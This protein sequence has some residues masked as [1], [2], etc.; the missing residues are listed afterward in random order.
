MNSLF[1]K[2][3]SLHLQ[4]QF[5]INQ[6]HAVFVNFSRKT[7][8]DAVCEQSDTTIIIRLSEYNY[9]TITLTS[10]HSFISIHSFVLISES[11]TTTTWYN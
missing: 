7:Q 6:A 1:R 9:L 4:Q 8:E 5:T 3:I 11:I 10:F 2:Q